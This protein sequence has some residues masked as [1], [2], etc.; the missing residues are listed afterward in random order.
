MEELHLAHFSV[1]EYLITQ[2]QFNLQSA[3]VSISKTCLAYLT[4]IRVCPTTDE[5]DFPMARFAAKHWTEFAVLARGSEE[6]VRATVSFLQNET[7]FRQWCQLY[8]AD[9][10]WPMPPGPPRASRLYYACLTG[11]AGAARNLIIEGADVNAQGGYYGNAL[12]AASQR[13]SFEVVQL[14]LDKGADVNVQ[15]GKY[16]NALRAAINRD[17]Q[18][19]VQVLLD[20]GADVDAQTLQAALHGGNPEIVQ[21]LNLNGAKLMSRKR[22]GSK[23]IRERMKLPQL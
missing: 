1:K 23:N 15:G 21:I 13:G 17:H 11:L 4:D 9:H 8:H 3:T 10:P 18:E 20:K 2:S 6:I 7:A 19:V 16:G 14:L 12:Q 5:S 22:S